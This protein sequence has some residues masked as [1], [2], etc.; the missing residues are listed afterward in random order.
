LYLRSFSVFKNSEN[1]S[2]LIEVGTVLFSCNF[3]EVTGS[4]LI[5]DAAT[6]DGLVMPTSST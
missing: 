6:A 4:A 5:N 2:C 3:D 1:F